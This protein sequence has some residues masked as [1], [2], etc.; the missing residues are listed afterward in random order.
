MGLHIERIGDVAVVEPHGMLRGGKETDELENDLRKLIHDQHPKIVLD[1]GKTT[2]LSSPAIGILA[3][4]HTSC[5]NRGLQLH[6][7]NIEKRIE[8]TLTIVKL[9]RVL[10]VFGTREEAI[11]AFGD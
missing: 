2:M 5:V 8:H 4:V 10:Y 9:V 6:V 11:A 1:L 7:C 3:S